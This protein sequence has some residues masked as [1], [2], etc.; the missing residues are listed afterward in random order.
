[1]VTYSLGVF[2][3]CVQGLERIPIL[4]EIPSLHRQRS[5]GCPTPTFSART[6]PHRQDSTPLHAT[7]RAA[8]PSDPPHRRRACAR[9]SLPRPELTDR[10]ASRARLRHCRRSAPNDDMT[11]DRQ[12]TIARPKPTMFRVNPRVNSR[13]PVQRMKVTI[14]RPFIC[15]RSSRR[16]ISVPDVESRAPGRATQKCVTSKPRDRIREPRPLDVLDQD[17]GRRPPYLL[18]R[19]RRP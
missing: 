2:Y 17:P 9:A 13:T 14:I 11:T 18:R 3:R 4:A 6:E 5:A 12:F 8:E 19:S 7:R 16:S 10:H 15:I 1:M